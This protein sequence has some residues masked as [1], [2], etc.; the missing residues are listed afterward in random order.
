MIAKRV[1][2]GWRCYG[3][4]CWN[5]GARKVVN[6]SIHVFLAHLGS[7]PQIHLWGS[8]SSLP[9]LCKDLWILLALEAAVQLGGWVLNVKCICIWIQAYPSACP[10]WRD[11]W[12]VSNFWAT[13]GHSKSFQEPQSGQFT[14][15]IWLTKSKGAAVI[16]PP[17]YHAV[18]I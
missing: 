14:K 10:C 11:K 4:F 16:M 15:D 13:A 7:F 8:Y 17:L 3:L 9:A 2:F 1:Y 18:L 5:N 12:R 6:P